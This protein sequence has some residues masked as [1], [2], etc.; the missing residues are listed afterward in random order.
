[1]I[2]RGVPAGANMAKPLE[3]TK[4]F[5]PCS[6]MVGTLGAAGERCSPVCA[7][8]AQLAGARHD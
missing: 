3:T 5:K 1:M 8:H 6:S 2:G 7:D 4:P